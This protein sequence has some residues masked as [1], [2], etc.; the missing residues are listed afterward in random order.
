MA[1]FGSVGGEEMLSYMM[2][3]DSM[4]E[5][6]GDDW[7]A[8]RDRIGA[9]LTAIQ[10]GDGSWSGHHCITSTTFVTAAAVMTLA[11]GEIAANAAPSSGAGDAGA[12]AKNS[13]T[14]PERG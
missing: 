12:N 14:T 10:N 11:S 1:G 8:W 2:I 5:E 3:S 7:D 13:Q 6:G 9:H 4:A